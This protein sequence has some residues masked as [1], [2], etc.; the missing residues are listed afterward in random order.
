M[1]S[2]AKQS[3]IW[4]PHSVQVVIS[5]R[6]VAELLGVAGAGVLGALEAEA[7]VLRRPRARSPRPRRR[8]G[9]LSLPGRA[10]APRP[11]R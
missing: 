8:L 11:R 2:K 3:C 9:G 10:L 7:A 5:G 4:S 6:L 1:T